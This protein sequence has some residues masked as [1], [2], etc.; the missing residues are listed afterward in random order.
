MAYEMHM[1][2]KNNPR[3]C[4]NFQTYQPYLQAGISRNIS[5]PERASQKSRQPPLDH[6]KSK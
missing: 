4:I 3:A 1:N 6:A 2:E 5:H